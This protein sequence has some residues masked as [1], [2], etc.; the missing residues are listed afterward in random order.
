MLASESQG[1]SRFSTALRAELSA[2]VETFEQ[3]VVRVNGGRINSDRINSGRI[4]DG[5]I[6]TDDAAIGS[7]VIWSADGHV[8]TNFHVVS[9][10]VV[11][12]NRPFSVLYGAGRFEAEVIGYDRSTDLALLKAPLEEPIPIVP[13]KRD[14]IRIGQLVLALGFPWGD[15]GTTTHGIISAV[16]AHERTELIRTDAV[17]APGNSGGPLVD[18]KGE[19]VGLNTMVTGDGQGFAI[20]SWIIRSF[21]ADILPHLARNDDSILEEVF[22]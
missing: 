20:P 15:A 3:S 8:V 4:L 9:H 21:V 2:L 19:L 16:G 7:G 5:R 1:L 22:I 17:L 6:Q 10:S 14:A 12:H 11:S 13:S 18:M